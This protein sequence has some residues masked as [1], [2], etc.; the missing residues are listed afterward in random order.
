[1][2]QKSSLLLAV[3]L[4]LSASTSGVSGLVNATPVERLSPLTE[5][6]SITTPQAA[7]FE[8]G[9]R[10]LWLW[11][12][13]DVD[14]SE[15]R[16]IRAARVDGQGEIAP[17]FVEV[18][19]DP[20]VSVNDFRVEQAPGGDLWVAWTAR[21]DSTWSIRA[22]PLG[23]LQEPLPPPTV[24]PS[25]LP[26]RDV[27]VAAADGGHALAAWIDFDFD[28]DVSRILF[29]PLSD[30][31]EALDAS[32]VALS[33]PGTLGDS[34]NGVAV[35]ALTATEF[36]LAWSEAEEP[37]APRLR[38]RRLINV[39]T[40]A[41]PDFVGF[42]PFRID[43]GS[44]RQIE[45]P[46]VVVLPDGGFAIAW[47]ELSLDPV[48]TQILLRFYDADG[49]PRGPALELDPDGRGVPPQ[50]PG[51][52]VDSGGLVVATWSSTDPESHVTRV[53]AR[54]I[55]ADG[56][57][58]GDVLTA[59][60]AEGPD[61]AYRNPSPYLLDSGEVLVLWDEGEP[62]SPILPPRCLGGIGKQILARRLLTTCG[63][64]EGLCLEDQRFQV[65]VAWNDP[66]S[67]DSGVGNPVS[68]TS[69]TGLF[70][71]FDADNLELVTKVI[72]GRPVNGKYWFFYGALSNVGYEISV[73][74][75]LTGDVRLYENPPGT[76][77]SFADTRAFPPEGFLGFD[78]DELDA[79]PAALERRA[80]R[81]SAS[82]PSHLTPPLCGT[83]ETQLCLNE[84]FSVTVEWQDFRSG[85]SGVGET[86]PLTRDTG[87]FWFFDENNVELVV[88][89]LDARVVNGHFWVFYGSLTDVAFTL[90][91][92]DEAEGTVATFE[93]PPGQ[94]ASDAD[95]AAFSSP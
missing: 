21:D 52:A 9:D 68:L 88:K 49:D 36:L 58:R 90:T 73:T 35:A 82:P 39:G 6:C 19:Q 67:G 83:T 74:D 22:R 41:E 61:V 70:W 12:E 2:F 65:E 80:F 60:Q 89:V 10:E 17:D 69:D 62:P 5:P 25:D 26:V 86:I 94:M 43:D 44:A 18:S 33:V 77:A 55:D 72:D 31:G 23:Q 14:A 47:Y 7:L 75:R 66:A 87:S 38:A 46:E 93:N 11:R 63:P 40:A 84:R 56:A 92:R 3:F 16:R 37:D 79:G 13:E 45:S 81:A 54:R 4:C 20:S 50:R 48:V 29:R 28:E 64:D 42:R 30:E 51:L 34:L 95:T 57:P 24:I 71:F 15:P 85:D 1:M 91:I 27:D 78:L 53:F 76:L 32:R 59:H 8:G